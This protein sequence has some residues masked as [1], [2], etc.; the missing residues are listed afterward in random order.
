VRAPA[1][2]LV[3]L[4]EGV[5]FEAGAIFTDAV[6]TPYHALAVR[7]GLRAGE[8]V[9]VFG[10]GGVGIHAVQIAR[11]LG[12]GLVLAVDVRPG[13]LARAK[14]AGAHE[15]VS[16]DG[17]APAKAVARLTAGGAD[18]AVDC[19]GRPESISQA[20]RSIRPGGRAV[21][22]GMGTEPISLPPP[23]LFAWREHAVIGSFG[24]TRTDL[25]AVI[26]MVRSGLL[27]LSRSIT[28]RLPLAEV[29]R[30]LAMLE[31]RESDHVRIVV[32]PWEGGG[33]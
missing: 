2:S 4:P 16:A 21:I 6:A 10:A 24:S 26:G 11:V 32:Q 12:A 18:L 22:V 7:G 5:S 3:P 23:A 31:G 1:S 14:E 29:N 15:T 28:G 27:D 25:D 20:V 13:A 19:V 17:G 33:T 8:S 9:A 30:A